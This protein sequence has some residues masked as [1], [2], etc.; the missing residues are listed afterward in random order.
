MTSRLGVIVWA[1]LA[2]ATAVAASEPGVGPSRV[3]EFTLTNVLVSSLREGRVVGSGRTD[4][5][6]DFRLD[7]PP[8]DQNV[9]LDAPSLRS[10]LARAPGGDPQ[11]AETLVELL[12]V[13]A[14][15]DARPASGGAASARHGSTAPAPVLGAPRSIRIPVEGASLRSGRGP[16]FPVRVDS[17]AGP[18]GTDGR[19]EGR[20]DPRIPT[21]APR[22]TAVT[23][24]IRL[25]VNGA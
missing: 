7:L 23:G 5:R 18:R 13:V 14:L 19:A 10:A 9:C 16:C 8:G 3:G 12:V 6:G 21:P 24:S 17:S 15:A 11:R 22:T 1:G 2:F 25:V 4:A 20:L